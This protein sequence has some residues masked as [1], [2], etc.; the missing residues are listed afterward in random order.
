M[1][2]PK[3]PK[4]DEK[5]LY[6]TLVGQLDSGASNNLIHKDVLNKMTPMTYTSTIK[7][8]NT[9]YGSFQTHTDVKID[10]VKL[11]EFTLSRSFD[12]TFSLFPKNKEKGD[13]TFVIGREGMRQLGLIQ[14]WEDDTLEWK[15]IAVPMKTHGHW[16]N[17]TIHH[18]LQQLKIVK[19]TYHQSDLRLVSRS[20]IHL[21]DEQK[22]TLYDVLSDNYEVF[23]GTKG[24]WT[25]AP[26]HIDLIEGSKPYNKSLIGYRLA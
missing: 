5:P 17:D 4:N 24:E 2:L 8:W 7:Q 3:E 21:N 16:T 20:Q 1:A 14:N 25:G 15:G 10:N 6:Y 26:V 11:P 23:K 13:Y 22:S 9:K 18:Q 12:P 19:P